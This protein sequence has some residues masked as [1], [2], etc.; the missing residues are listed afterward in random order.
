MAK[1]CNYVVW[2]DIVKFVIQFYYFLIY[3]Q[4]TNTMKKRNYFL[5]FALFLCSLN[6]LSS[7]NYAALV[8]GVTSLQTT[9]TPGE[10]VTT[11]SI[12]SAAIAG[13]PSAAIS[14]ASIT[15]SNGK[16]LTVAHEGFFIDNEINFASNLTFAS[17]AMNWLCPANRKSILIS[18]GHRE[19]A[20]P[21]NLFSFE[22][23][24]ISNG[25]SYTFPAGGLTSANLSGIGLVVIGNAWGDI[26]Q[27]ELDALAAHLQSGGGILAMGL[28]WSW[29]SLAADYPMNKVAALAGQRFATPTNP[30]PFTTFYPNVLPNVSSNYC[31]SKGN[32]PWSEWIANVQFGTINNTSSKEGYGNFTTQTTTV[33]KGTSY[34][35][36]ITQGFS[37]APDP[38]NTTQQGKVWIDYNQNGI[39]EDV[40]LAASLTR[41]TATAN[42]TIPTTALTGA[43]RMRVS[44]K[45]IGAPTACEIFE[46]GEV[47]DYSVNITGGVVNTQPDLT[48]TDVVAPSSARVNENLT[49]SFRF[50]N[51]GSTAVY[52]PNSF[53]PIQVVASLVGTNTS[54]IL[55]IPIYKDIAAGS[56]SLITYNAVIPP[57][58]AT[59][60]YTLVIEAD[61][62]NVVAESN[63]TN[64]KVSVPLVI[65]AAITD[66][67]KLI[68]S[69]VTGATTGEPN[70][71]IPL[72]ITI[73]NTGTLPSAPDSVFI[74]YWRQPGFAL[75]YFAK[76]YSKNKVAVPAIAAG[77]SAV[78]NA[79]FQLPSPLKTDVSDFFNREE[80]YI[81]LKSKEQ[82]SNSSSPIP[83]AQV[84]AIGYYYPIQPAT[85]TDLVLTGTQLNPTWD[86]INN[87]ID[88]KLSLT[89]NGTSVAKNVYVNIYTASVG[90]SQVGTF[91]PDITDFVKLSGVGDLTFQFKVTGSR[92]ENGIR[93][94]YWILPELAAGATVEATFSG[95]I[96]GLQGPQ[97]N[98]SSY[99]D[100]TV[101]SNIQYA[102]VRDN[103]RANDTT[104]AFVYRN[105][106]VNSNSSPDL[107]LAN[108]TVQ[109]PSVLQGNIL[110]FKVDAKNIGTAAA[111]GNFT[112]KS[113]LSS[114]Q[115]LDASD[116]QNGSIPT[117]NFTAGLTQTQV[118]GAMLVTNAVA[119]GN[120]YLILKIDA[121]DQIA[122]N[123]EG[124]NTIIASTAI[125]VTA[126]GPTCFNKFEM[127]DGF[128]LAGQCS[129]NQIGGNEFGTFQMLGTRISDGFAYYT[130][131]PNQY[132]LS[133]N[134][135]TKQ[136]PTTTPP[137]GV[138]FRTCTGVTNWLYFVVQGFSQDE[139]FTSII[140]TQY[141]RVGFYGAETNPD[142][143][144]IESAE[145]NGRSR[146]AKSTFKSLSCSPC[147]TNDNT[148]PVFT[149]C[150]TTTITYSQPFSPNALKIENIINRGFGTP[151]TNV[152][153]TDNCSAPMIGFQYIN[154]VYWGGVYPI[155]LIAFDSAGNKSTCNFNL[156]IP[157]SPSVFGPAIFDCP[158]NIN[159]Q[160][161]AGQTCATAT[162][163]PPRV[164]IGGSPSRLSSNFTSGACFPIGST[165]VIYT[166]S[167]S[168]GFTATC[169]FTVTVTGV[170]TTT[171][172]ASKGIAPWEYW[173]ANVQLGSIN[174]ASDKFKDFA[175]LGYSD[176]TNLSTTLNKGTSYPLSIS[177]GLSWIGNVPNAYCRVWIDF[178]QNKTF[179]AN[180]LVLEKTN[181]N[182]LTQSILIP[183]TALTGNTR[184]RVA[185]K[186]GAYPTAC[187]TFDRGEVED[188]TITIGGG[189]VGGT[190]QLRITNVTG[191]ASARPGDAITLNVTV[192]NAGG[193]ATVPTKLSYQ[194]RNFYGPNFLL[195]N[196][197]I[198]V[199]A[200]AANETRTISYPLT[201][202]NPVFPPNAN[203]LNNGSGGFGTYAFSDY[204]VYASNNNLSQLG[205][206]DSI[207]YKYNIS[208]IYP[209]ANISLNVVPNKT[210]LQ[211]AETWNATYSVKN[212]SNI[213]VKQLFVN[214]GTFGNLNRNNVP[215]NFQIETIS[216]Q[217][218]NS[219]IRTVSTSGERF[220]NGWEVLNLAAGETRTVT[221]NFSRIVTI[222][223]FNSSDTSTT[224]ITLEFPTLNSFS[225]VVNTNTSVGVGIPVSVVPP[226]S[227]N[228]P[229]LRLFSLTPT[230][231]T[232]AQGQILNFTF[233][234]NNNGPL[235]ATGNFNI[236]SYLSTDQTL[237]ADDYQDGNI[238]TA[239][240]AAFTTTSNVAGA[241]TVRNTVPAGSYYLILKVDADNQITELNENNNDAV[242]GFITV[243]GGTTGGGADLALSIVSTPSVFRKYSVNTMRV[244]AQNVGNQTL[245]NVKV[246]LKR[247]ALTSN[248]GSKVAS[249]GSFQDF[250][251]GG[252]ECSEWTI[253]TLAAGATATLDAPFFILD[254][255]APIVVTTKL[256]SSTPVDGN[257][258]NNTATV[259]I[260]P[261]AAGAA[262]PILGLRRQTPTQYI[263][264]V[265]QSIA[266]NPTE[267]DVVVEV[268]SL[269]AQDVQFEFSNAMGQVIQ[270][271]KRAVEKG[272][273]QVHFDVYEFT[274]GIYFIQTNVGKG[275][276]APTKFV[277]F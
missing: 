95:R 146:L 179:E 111:T 124:N 165:T 84:K 216:N 91:I 58:R 188:Y 245:T 163:A 269:T 246:E 205:F 272:T 195:T 267:G 108:L 32:T 181:Q 208:M 237:S 204:Y 180:E 131:F 155:S 239:N 201:L 8:A 153:V 171:Y 193:G 81:L 141:V 251:P 60:N 266:P 235:A 151:G 80:P 34:P 187:E 104:A 248:G 183:A 162:W 210:I 259:S 158:T 99:K 254:A 136:P 112:I 63:E 85:V 140:N 6:I 61:N 48:I 86:S 209:Q 194:Q 147:V 114:D 244:T 215:S 42:I 77:Q 257:V 249:V 161:A 78:V 149:N 192:T 186:F 116:Y 100:Y 127:N 26:S 174:N 253:P 125:I 262:A 173:V 66:N 258:A 74:A 164:S 70:G 189:T 43:T 175:T 101:R 15:P 224:T 87:K 182:P 276:N 271:E 83:L 57:F 218:A 44:L 31:A 231:T 50:K 144:I 12:S 105:V 59:G 196:D 122:E 68:V 129:A 207:N 5:S 119:A 206:V 169:S 103:N 255:N 159:L 115:I 25:Y 18:T 178:N 168:C 9:G 71:T 19:W 202:K 212:N 82:L 62:T 139:R 225:N 64:N 92:E 270:S 27:A 118:A 228:L 268:E 199:P 250:C 40:E 20:N 39:F 41:T 219:I 256:L 1:N 274:Q 191:P 273:N 90:N 47:E 46:K 229:D 277:K 160:A 37:W 157:C 109:T 252:I 73:Q 69:N 51:L 93:Y 177:P 232:V 53:N 72:S 137:A 123:N 130:N 275:R 132:G 226:S 11:T 150:P 28:G 138:I 52:V 67:A 190:S 23:K 97:S 260:S 170:T 135:F 49:F 233:N 166:A 213:T 4:K 56:D 75:G 106:T 45:T 214:I 7:Q 238:A 142:S 36:S 152:Q 126:G 2:R 221:F 217:T 24:A 94:H 236:K 240:L 134:Y 110:N 211:R 227:A 33:A 89:N 35:L 265:V 223:D 113:Y 102:D 13:K 79:T 184:M 261:A 30:S 230:T 29:S 88:L 243:T 21:S 167:D 247:P 197:S 203:F 107:T 220:T 264:L 156:K 128:A 198:L 55:Y 65:N 145:S 172:C 133:A 200:L 98:I 234:L 185:L 16:M 176:Y 148:P 222:G 143:I 38:A 22:N 96:V 117:A 120:Y 154:E 242:I 76:M 14:I 263:P 10:M 54:T 17:N 121:D 3:Y 241:M